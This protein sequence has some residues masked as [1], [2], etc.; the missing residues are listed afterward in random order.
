MVSDVLTASSPSCARAHGPSI[1]RSIR[2]LD[3]CCS[4]RRTRHSRSSP[5]GLRARRARSCPGAP[6]GRR[7]SRASPGWIAR[8]DVVRDSRARPARRPVEVEVDQRSVGPLDAA[9]RRGRVSPQPPKSCAVRSVSRCSPRPTSSAAPTRS[10][11]GVSRCVD[12]DVHAPVV[13]ERDQRAPHARVDLAGDRAR[14]RQR[15]LAQVEGQQPEPARVPLAQVGGGRRA[16]RGPATALGSMCTPPDGERDR[17]QHERADRQQRPRRAEPRPARERADQHAQATPTTTQP[18]PNT[19]ADRAR[20]GERREAEQRAAGLGE[21]RRCRAGRRSAVLALGRE[22]QPRRDVD[23]HAE[24]DQHARR[25]RSR[26]ARAPGETSQRRA[27]PAQTPPSQ[28]PCAG[29]G[30]RSGKLV[31]PSRCI[32]GRSAV[33]TSR[34]CPEAASRDFPDR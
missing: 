6:R 1:S 13:R 10:S 26:A 5:L 21:Q 28:R 22:D 14:L 34:D 32:V 19:V 24:P 9:C 25:A 20:G 31:R 11:G 7:G 4:A 33:P 30:D 15:G 16:R 23:E 27:R 3:A 12:V 8:V 29:A 17:R 18:K 2:S